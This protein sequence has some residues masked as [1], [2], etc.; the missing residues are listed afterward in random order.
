MTARN[1]SRRTVLSASVA[2][3]AIVAP[4]AA[5]VVTARASD[6]VE[7]LVASSYAAERAANAASDVET[8]ALKALPDAVAKPRITVTLR[9]SGSHTL[10]SAKEID[11]AFEREW[12]ADNRRWLPAFSPELLDAWKLSQRLG[13]QNPSPEGVAAAADFDRRYKILTDAIKKEW[14]DEKA[15]AVAQFEKAQEAAESEKDRLGFTALHERTEELWDRY[16]DIQRKIYATSATTLAGLAARL[17][18]LASISLEGSVPN[19]DFVVS[20][21]D[22]AERLAG[23]Q[24]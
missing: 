20:L 7:A 5:L 4:A 11:D 2:T 15:R 14:H 19:D 3:V 10:H 24:A 22:N 8:A 13:P 1:V 21:A 18:V 12:W 16:F 6:P 9:F 23:A 17:R